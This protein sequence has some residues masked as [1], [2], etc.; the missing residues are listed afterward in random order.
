MGSAR[1]CRSGVGGSFERDA[2]GVAGKRFSLT[3]TLRS[4]DGS[5]TLVAVD[6]RGRR[7]MDCIRCAERL[8]ALQLGNRLRETRLRQPERR[9]A[10]AW[11]PHNNVGGLTRRPSNRGAPLRR[12]SG[13]HQPAAPLGAFASYTVAVPI[14]PGAI[15][16]GLVQ[17]LGLEPGARWLRLHPAMR[18]DWPLSCSCDL[19]EFGPDAELGNRFAVRLHRKACNWPGSSRGSLVARLWPAGLCRIAYSSPP[20]RR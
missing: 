2:L 7:G 6:A 9:S 12:A 10:A 17:C 1:P 20:V 15:A 16:N 18:T 11:L 4:K 5:A 3:G 13:Y 19:A 8:Y 14:E